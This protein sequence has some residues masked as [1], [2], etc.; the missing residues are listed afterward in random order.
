M[1]VAASY[2]WQSVLLK[3]LWVLCT[4]KFS[5]VIKKYIS[6][7]TI[8]W[9]ISG[10]TVIWKLLGICIMLAFLGYLWLL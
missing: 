3:S 1:G 2:Q 7:M 10:M 8:S 4:G 9:Y 5:Q 6:G